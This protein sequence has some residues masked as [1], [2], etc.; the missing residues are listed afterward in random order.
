[1][2]HQYY[3]CSDCNAR[4]LISYDLVSLLWNYSKVQAEVA[5][6]EIE[7]NVHRVECIA[8]RKAGVS[9]ERERSKG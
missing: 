3:R 1:M 9:C 4:Y 8:N 5:L 7:F 6:I 2:I